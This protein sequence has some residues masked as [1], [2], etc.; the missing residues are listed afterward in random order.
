M[1]STNT[2]NSVINRV[3]AKRPAPGKLQAAATAPTLESKRSTGKRSKQE[4][5]L[6]IPDVSELKAMIKALMTPAKPAQPDAPIQTLV[7]VTLDESGSMSH[8]FKQTMKG[9]NDQMKV[10]RKTAKQIGCRVMQTTFNSSAKII[11]EDVTADFIVPLS[12]ET[13]D[14]SGGTALYDT[15]A[16]V[17]SRLLAHPLAHQD[18][19]SILLMLTTDGEDTSSV[20]WNASKKLTEFRAL[21]KAVSKNDRWSV[22]LA[23]PDRMLR[24]FSDE[25]SVDAENVASFVPT[26]IKSRSDAMQSSVHAMNSYAALRSMG[27]KKVSTMHAGTVSGQRAKEILKPKP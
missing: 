20:K 24:Q 10:L 23:G 15:V 26:D 5:I 17:V 18:N 7:A 3:L 8:G 27:T 19:T 9:Y 21:M 25:L 11:T 6:D 13:Y 4:S 2:A 12:T 1:K 16:A 22:S 14:P